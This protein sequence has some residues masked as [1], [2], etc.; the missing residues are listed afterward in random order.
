MYT[1]YTDTERVQCIQIQGVYSVYWY[2]AYT[3]YTDTGCKH[4]IDTVRVQYIQIQN[5]CTI[6]IQFVYSVYRYRVYALFR[7]RVCTVYNM[8]SDTGWI[9]IHESIKN[10]VCSTGVY[11]VYGYKVQY[12]YTQDYFQFWQVNVTMLHY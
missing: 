7:Y 2:R 9:Q 3:V 8:F 10:N 4:Y 5:V 12:M 11:N 6:Q 1:V